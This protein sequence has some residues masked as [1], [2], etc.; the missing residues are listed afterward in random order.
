MRTGCPRRGSV[1]LP[2]SRRQRT[3]SER[4]SPP[5]G[6]AYLFEGP[7]SRSTKRR[8]RVAVGLACVLTVLTGA[9]PGAAVAQ[10]TASVEHDAAQ[11]RIVGGTRT[12]T[13]RAPWMVALTDRF[14]RQFCGGAL[15]TATKVVTAAH[16]TLDRR[17]D[18]PRAAEDLRVVVGR[19]DLRSQAGTV[20]RVSGVWRHPNFT[21]ITGGADVAMLTLSNPVSQQPLPMVRQGAEAEYRAGTTGEVYGWGRTGESEASSPVLRSVRVPVMADAR[22]AD[23]YT[24]YDPAGMFCAGL[25]EGGKDA[26][27][28]DSGGPF[29]VN[30]RLAGIV[31]FGNGCARKGYPGV[32]TRVAAYADRLD[33]ARTR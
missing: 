1:P 19:T 6:P 8:A 18:S 27:A 31:S 9:G 25:P 29:V 12:S 17:R 15:V 4:Y 2:R 21:T 28:G 24:S 14:G 13:E 16:C 33:A 7:G 11:A 26:C 10:A 5:T 22:C 3:S 30:G 32:Y 20:A 23:A